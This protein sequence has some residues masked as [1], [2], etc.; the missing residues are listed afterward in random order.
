VEARFCRWLLTCL[1]RTHSNELQLT[2][3]FL[4]MMLGVQRT[5]VTQVAGMLQ[6]SGLIRSQRGRV[7]ILDRAGLERRSCECYPVVRRH[8]E[9]VTPAPAEDGPCVAS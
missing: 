5:T 8:F 4:A 7:E 2:Q 1:D 9:A 6:A 3:E